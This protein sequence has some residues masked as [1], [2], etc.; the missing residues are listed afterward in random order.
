MAEDDDQLQCRIQYTPSSSGIQTLTASYWG[1]P[2]H[3]SSDDTAVIFSG[4]TAPSK[5]TALSLTCDQT[6]PQ[7]GQTTNCQATVQ[8][9]EGGTASGTVS[10]SASDQGELSHA[11]CDSP[12]GNGQLQCNARYSPSAVGAQVVTATYSGDSSHLSSTGTFEVFVQNNDYSGSMEQAAFFVPV[13]AILIGG[14]R[15]GI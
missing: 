15:C 6:C 14:I 7:L 13:G 4:N 8:T 12:D 3:S 1:D 2:H 10:W 11:R 5:V 9:A